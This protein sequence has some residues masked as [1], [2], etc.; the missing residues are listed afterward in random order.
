[1][2]QVSYLIIVAMP[3]VGQLGPLT[4]VA[5]LSAELRNPAGVEVLGDGTT[6]VADLSKNQI[7]RFDANG[8]LIGTW[9]VAEGPIDV[10]ANATG[11]T[12][13][14]SLRDL[15]TV[16]VYDSSFNRTG[17]LGEGDP[18][19]SFVGPTDIDVAGD[20]GIAYLVDARRGGRV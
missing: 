8:A 10:A 12:F 15:G 3:F 7:V 1:M 14:V 2:V 20:T 9:P 11:M 13:Y 5:S 17:F 6:L 18:M 19:V 4:H 16:A